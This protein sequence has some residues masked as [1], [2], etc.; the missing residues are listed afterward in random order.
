MKESTAHPPHLYWHTTWN[1]A[2]SAFLKE[3]PTTTDTLP[4][5]KQSK[6][7]YTFAMCLQQHKTFKWILEDL[8]LHQRRSEP[9]PGGTGSSCAA[10]QAQGARCAQLLQDGV[11]HWRQPAGGGGGLH[12]CFS[13]KQQH[14][15]APTWKLLAG[16]Q[17]HLAAT[18]A[19]AQKLGRA[20]RAS[21]T[22]EQHAVL[23][24]SPW[25]GYQLLGVQKSNTQDK[26]RNP[27]YRKMLCSVAARAAN[28]N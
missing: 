15:H 10:Q 19:P 4:W 20:S 25:Y 1:S 6:W 28:S 2:S 24:P 7:L 3:H 8:W 17:L 5:E 12:Y 27:I 21:W 16:K 22:P 9:S 14:V 13:E 11:P 26:E 23:T 18:H